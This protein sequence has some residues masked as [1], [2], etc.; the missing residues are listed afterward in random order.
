[1]VVRQIMLWIKKYAPR[2]SYEIVNQSEAVSKLKDFIKNYRKYKKKAM[3][4]W[5]PPGVG[6]TCSVYAI[7]RELNYEV[8]ELNASDTR[9]ARSIHEK[10][11]E[12]VKGK[13]FF[14]SG[15]VILIDEVDGLTGR[16]DKGGVGAIVNIIEE[17]VWPIVLTANDPW[18][19]KLRKLRDICE[20]VEFKKLSR[21]DIFKVLKKIASAEKLEVEDNVL[22]ALAQR[23]QGDL[24]SA[25]N[26]L[27]TL[28]GLGKRITLQDLSVLGYREREIEIFQALAHMF[29]ANT[30]SSA[31]I[32]FIN[33]DMDPIEI[34]GWIEENIS[35][36]Y[37]DIE[38]IFEAYDWMS[39]AR[40]FYG[41]IYV[42]QYWELLK[43]YTTLM[44]AGV[45]LA[46][47]RPYKK[48][49]RYKMPTYVRRLARSKDIRERLENL[50][51]DLSKKVHTSRKRT[52]EVY[53]NV[54]YGLINKHPD[55]AKKYLKK[56]G[57]KESEA[58][59][60]I[61]ALKSL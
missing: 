20:L 5:G 35:R 11:D 3:L 38:E 17:S 43:Y 39:K 31:R 46:K 4:L 40:I 22:W 19:P 41:R 26:D 16:Y 47:K 61:Q 42:R 21:T 12:A 24:R 2:N 8:V 9:T 44:Y 50:L 30:L 57:L 34:E 14:H 59:F 52:R 54:V 32:A 6:K 15:R 51:K 49:T 48:F 60:I 45:A 29:K 37:E 10:L 18:D 55:I 23:S 33:V 28:A 13:P 36:E 1:M 53:I 7:A 56:L 27:Q 58:D 25:I